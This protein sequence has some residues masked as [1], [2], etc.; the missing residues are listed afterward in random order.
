[1]AQDP[2]EKHTRSLHIP[3]SS[4]SRQGSVRRWIP[5]PDYGEK[6]CNGSGKL[7]GKSAVI[8]GGDGSI[9]RAVA[10]AFAREGQTSSYLVPERG[11]RREGN[12]LQW[13][14]PPGGNA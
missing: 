2:R 11:V 6:S 1:M 12:R 9:G 5:K 10:L 3:P 14:R 13:S 8:T 7:K 4:R